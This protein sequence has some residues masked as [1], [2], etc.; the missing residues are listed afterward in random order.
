MQFEI[1]LHFQIKQLIEIL[2]SQN[3]WTGFYKFFQNTKKLFQSLFKTK[4]LLVS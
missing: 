2:M 4:L 3:L 1:S